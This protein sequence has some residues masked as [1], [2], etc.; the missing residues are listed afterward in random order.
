VETTTKHCHQFEIKLKNFEKDLKRFDLTKENAE[1][2][3]I[4]DLR[5]EYVDKSNIEECRKI[6][7]FIEEHEW[8][9]RMPNRPTHRFVAYLGDQII[10]VN[11]FGTPYS[12]SSLLG[13]DN[14]GLEKLIARGASISFAP[15]NI[16]S[17]LIKKSINWM[18]QNTEFRFFSAYCDTEALELG[19]IYQACNFIYVGKK[20]GGK[21]EYYD[22]NYPN[23][24]W[25]SDRVARRAG[26]YRKFAKSLGIEWKKEWST[27]C[28]MNWD[29]MPDIVQKVL[30]FASKDYLDKCQVKYCVPKHKYIYIQGRNKKETQQLLNLFYEAN[31]KF[32][33]KGPNLRPGLPYPKV[34]GQ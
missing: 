2:I 1:K 32:R 31:P 26:Q 14:W 9:K 5:F 16:G 4:I 34:R 8:L 25:F 29:L 20:A 30:K 19:T 33:P 3:R 22:P 13:K 12:K 17:W 23:R 11:V 24:G 27:E 28:T 15:K 18:V 21:T 7:R 6:A 10:A